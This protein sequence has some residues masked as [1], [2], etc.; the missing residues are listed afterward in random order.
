[1]HRS[2]ILAYI[3]GIC[4]MQ[5]RRFDCQNL[6]KSIQKKAEAHLAPPP[7]CPFAESTH[8]EMYLCGNLSCICELAGFNIFQDSAHAIW[9][10][11]VCNWSVFL[12]K[13]I[14]ICETDECIRHRNTHWLK[15][16]ILAPHLL[17]YTLFWQATAAAVLVKVAPTLPNY[18][19]RSQTHISS[20]ICN[21]S[22][23]QRI[24]K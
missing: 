2:P 9:T 24:F 20:N 17:N 16:W 23:F 13:P 1:M 22:E 18:V 19:S 11:W 3:I 4:G 7:V 14:S 5:G 12:W 15:Q 6:R 10:I 21:G 8:L